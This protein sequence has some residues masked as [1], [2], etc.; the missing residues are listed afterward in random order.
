MSRKGNSDSNKRSITRYV[1]HQTRMASLVEDYD[2]GVR[3]E[4]LNAAS[5][6]FDK[7]KDYLAAEFPH[8]TIPESEFEYK[9]GS[10][11]WSLRVP[12]RRDVC[13]ASEQVALITGLSR[14]M[15][16]D[17][18]RPI[19]GYFTAPACVIDAVTESFTRALSHEFSR[20]QANRRHPNGNELSNIIS[21]AIISASHDAI[22][23]AV[24][25]LDGITPDCDREF[26]LFALHGRSETG[27]PDPFSSKSRFRNDLMQALIWWTLPKTEFPQKRAGQV[28]MSDMAYYF[29]LAGYFDEPSNLTIDHNSKKHQRP[30]VN[31]G[32]ERT[33]RRWMRKYTDPEYDWPALRSHIIT[34]IRRTGYELR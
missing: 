13:L 20:A 18:C 7:V 5:I 17:G 27:P 10:N 29:S 4:G 32:D 26:I 34:I 6:A 2:S 12:L 25:A 30:G 23:E 28:T 11:S 21:M 8:K 33:V 1:I 15:V 14:M 22:C 3:L 31:G 19:P 9:D 16:L 24:D